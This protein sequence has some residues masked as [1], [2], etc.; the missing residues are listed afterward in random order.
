MSGAVD[1]VLLLERRGYRGR[2]EVRGG[3]QPVSE[4][5]FDIQGAMDGWLQVAPEGLARAVIKTFG[6]SDVVT[7]D[8]QFDDEHEISASSEAFARRVLDADTRSLLRPVGAYSSF[9]FRLTPHL[10]LLRVERILYDPGELETLLM[11]AS[12]LLGSL[13]LPDANAVDVGEM[14]EVLSRDAQCEVCGSKL[15]V[16]A[17]VRCRKCRTPHHRDCWE[18]N[19]VCS[20]FACGS[21]ESE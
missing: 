4:V 6:V 5:T 19:G 18:F 9:V 3:R 1:P 16:G 14:R 2:A 12:N 13:G 7:G 10:L 20:T 15:S 8:D 11:T 17:V 21:R